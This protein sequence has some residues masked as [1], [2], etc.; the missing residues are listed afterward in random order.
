MPVFDYA[1][2]AYGPA[3]TIETGMRQPFE[4]RVQ[5]AMRV[6]QAAVAVFEQRHS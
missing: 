3:L 4:Q 2:D 1:A 6:A 5:T